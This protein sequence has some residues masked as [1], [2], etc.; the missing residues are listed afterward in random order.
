MKARER[1]S[2]AL[3]RHG[4]PADHEAHVGHVDSALGEL[5]T[6]LANHRRTDATPEEIDAFAEVAMKRHLQRSWQLKIRALAQ[7]PEEPK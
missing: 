7:R 2:E 6:S 3:V 1:L 5:A 4:M